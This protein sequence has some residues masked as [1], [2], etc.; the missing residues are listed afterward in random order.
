VKALRLVMF[1]LDGTLVDTAPEITAAVNVALAE[2]GLPAVEEARVRPWMGEGARELMKRAYRHASG[3]EPDARTLQGFEWH[4]AA[5]SGRSS[6]LLPEALA[7]LRTLRELGVA[8]ALLTNKETRFTAALLH[9]HDLWGC[10]DAVVC[11]DMLEHGKPNPL[12][13][14]HCLARFRTAPQRA[15]L[16]GES[17]IDVATARN[18]GIRIVPTL[19]ALADALEQSSLATEN[20]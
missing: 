3:A 14:E 8:T 20:R 17:A 12:G 7:A 18:A 13:V 2:S 4:Y 16:A 19:R 1:D 5:L 6:R 9:A 11:G 15:L 10:L